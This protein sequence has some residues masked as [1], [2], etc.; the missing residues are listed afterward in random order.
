MPNGVFASDLHEPYV[1]YYDS[2]DH[3]PEPVVQEVM[4]LEEAP[5]PNL[6]D[7]DWR[8]LLS[9][10]MVEGRLPTDNTKARHIACRAKSF[11]LI[12]GHLYRRGAAGILMR[13]I[14]TDQGR[15]LL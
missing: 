6:E 1:R 4:A 3:P 13:Y 15:E 2:D 14:H 10:W 8:I 12:N 9:K 7:P 5:E 11:S